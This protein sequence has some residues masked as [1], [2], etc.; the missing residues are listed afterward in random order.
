MGT[1]NTF[2]FHPDAIDKVATKA[3]EAA[4][5][6]AEMIKRKISS[7]TDNLKDKT[8]NI[9]DQVD[10]DNLPSEALL[11]KSPEIEDEVERKKR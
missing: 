3:K 8:T 11:K 9:L 6:A 4:S 7:A 1:I 10:S 5:S 2:N